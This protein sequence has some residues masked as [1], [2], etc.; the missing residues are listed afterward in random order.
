MIRAIPQARD[1]PLKSAVKE[2]ATFFLTYTLIHSVMNRSDFYVL[3]HGSSSSPAGSVIVCVRTCSQAFLSC[4]LDMYVLV[5][6]CTFEHVAVAQSRPRLADSP[7]DGGRKNPF[8]SIVSAKHVRTYE[9]TTQMA[10]GPP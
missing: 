1:K 9:H 5:V 2:Y 6:A 3:G 8:A 10:I 4:S 7:G